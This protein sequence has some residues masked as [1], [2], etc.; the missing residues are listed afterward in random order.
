MRTVAPHEAR[1]RRQVVHALLSDAE[2]RSTTAGDARAVFV[3]GGAPFLVAD[4]PALVAQAPPARR[5]ALLSSARAAM[6]DAS[7]KERAR[8]SALAEIAARVSMTPRML[9]AHAAGLDE[10]DLSHF[11]DRVMAS[12]ARALAVSPMRVDEVPA[13]LLAGAFAVDAG[14]ALSGGLVPDVSVERPLQRAA[15]AR[16]LVVDGMRDV[17]LV[18]G[19]TDTAVARLAARRARACVQ[20]VRAHAPDA[21]A[22]TL[23]IQALEELSV[24]VA[25]AG[26]ARDRARLLS[27]RAL[28]MHVRVALD[29]RIEDVVARDA[30]ASTWADAQSPPVPGAALLMPPIDAAHDVQTLVARLLARALARGLTSTLGPAWSTASP[31]IV[32]DALRQLLAVLSDVGVARYLLT[33]DDDPL[34]KP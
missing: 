2:R 8:S 7:Q 1:V 14:H 21:P 31:A 10:R 30:L 20:A 32:E 9:L 27:L 15:Q 5:M 24:D 25:R 16:C 4:L 11:A 26:E 3:D 33:L 13:A 22:D 34:L 28:A 23:V 12:T 19:T 18:G 29:A 6:P 17:R